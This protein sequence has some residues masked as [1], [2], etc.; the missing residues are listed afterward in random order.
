MAGTTRTITTA[1][2][3]DG[4]AEFKKQMSAVNSELK[5]L[6]SELKLSESE[7]KGQ[8]N[9][10]DALTAKE[11]VLKDQI[12]QQKV[13]VDA[14]TQAVK[15][16]AEAYGDTDKRT[17]SYR[18]QLNNAKISLNN[19]NDDLRKNR[20]YMDEARSSTDGC[21]TS[22]DGYG[23]EVTNAT[24]GTNRFGDVLKANLASDAIIE[25]AKQLAGTLKEI[26]S[27][28]VDVAK[29]G[30][31]LASNLS[32]VENVV[33]TTFGDG[34]QKIYAWSDAAAEA[35]GMS[36]LD[37]E[38]Y[39]GTIGAMLKSMGM[40]SDE[41]TE[42]STGLVGL[43]GDMAS[44]YNL[45]GAEAFEKI[46]SGI[47]GETEPLKQLGINMSVANLEAYALSEGIDKS[48]DSMTQ[49]EQT[50]LRYNYLMKATSDAQGDFAKTSG[51][52][53]NQQRILELNIQNIEAALGEKLLPTVLEVT[54]AFNNLVA[55]NIDIGQ[56]MD[57]LFGMNQVT[58]D[59]QEF[60]PVISAA[61]TAIIAYKGAAAISGVIDKLREATEGQ[62][63]AQAALN[64][65]MDANPFVL[66]ATVVAAVTAALV[67]AYKTN[68]EFRDKVNTAWNELKDTAEIVF[69]AIKN[70]I[71]S[72]GD[73]FDEVRTAIET[74]ITEFE[75]IGENIVSGIWDGIS[76]SYD[77]IKGKITGWVGNVVEFFKSVLGVHET[78]SSGAVRYVDGSHALGLKY[79][80]FDGYIAELHQGERVLTAQ[81]ASIINS[82]SSVNLRTPSVGITDAQLQRVTAGAVN[83]LLTGQVN[84]NISIKVPLNINGREFAR[85]TIDDIR[86]VS[87]SDP[88][89]ASEF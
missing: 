37:A 61:A 12:E 85:A 88:E 52:Y 59:F 53:A 68:D 9:T 1:I 63:A 32:E 50:T 89:I 10:V 72:V 40:T 67:V 78:V 76:N 26:G 19:L 43:S 81:E 56:F 7:F 42:M 80:P 23:K 16:S 66:I 34:A 87:K 57:K 18:Q 46:R 84:Q 31:E 70:V 33:N 58:E 28:F 35:F 69:G 8:A 86:A 49:A 62:T 11:K 55:G 79:V 44:F 77:W 4:E 3:L 47:S 83:A 30:I 6:S 36:K 2:K 71:G 45:D 21:A 13:K 17:D 38:K 82:L 74:K 60:L 48:Y 20:T 27:R 22:I 25:G 65:V 5:N 75:S 29:D 54:T 41:V 64:V 24:N 73:K 15:D 14:L 39:N 51:G